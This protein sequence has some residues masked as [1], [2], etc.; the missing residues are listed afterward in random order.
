M[1]IC[2]CLA[3]ACK[4]SRAPQDTLDALSTAQRLPCS[5]QSDLHLLP[6]H[7]TT[8]TNV[9]SLLHLWTFAHVIPFSLN[10]LLSVS[11]GNLQYTL[12]SVPQTCPMSPHFRTKAKLSPILCLPTDLRM[13][14]LKY[15]FHLQASGSL[16]H[17]YA[18]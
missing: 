6:Y 3:P 7:F 2:P 1:Q 11:H 13:F 5:G 14:L 17:K 18:K 10:I 12:L 9:A 16:P 4:P 15:N 8:I